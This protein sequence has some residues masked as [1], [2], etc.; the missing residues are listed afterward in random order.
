M[1]KTISINNYIL[2]AIIICIIGF[3]LP[4]LGALSSDAVKLLALF[5][6]SLLMWIF[7]AID[8]PSLLTILALGLV[9]AI[10]FG[11]AFSSAFGNSTVAFLI[12]TF[13]LVYPL[14]KTNF[15]KRCT[16]FFITNPLAAKG[17]W[18]FVI[19]LLAAVTFMGLFISP[20]VLFVAFMPFLE[21]IFKTLDLKKGSPSAKM[22]MT[23][24]AICINLS[25]GMT[26]IGHVWPT[27]A[28]GYYNSATGYNIGQFEY[29]AFG[30]PA[31][32]LIIALVLA[33]YRFIL[34][35]ADLKS[36][37][38]K[39]AEA[40]KK[41]IPQIEKSEKIILAVLALTVFLWVMPSL[42]SGVWPAF[43]ELLNSY[44]SAFPPLL[45]CLILFCINIDNK[46]LLDFK[47]ACTKGIMWGS[48]L[49]TAAATAL[50]A[51]LTSSEIG[52]S[53]FLSTYLGPLAQNL[54]PLLM[55]MFFMAWA[56]IETNF[57]SNIVTTTVVSSVALSIL[58]ALPQGSINIGAVLAM[59]GFAAAVC[60][61][62]P[63][64]Q[65]TVNTVAIGSGYTDTKT[66]FFIGLITAIIAFIV[67]VFLAYP[68]ASA[69]MPY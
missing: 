29:M 59:I 58:T 34:Y 66:M 2:A 48:V 69:L 22:L 54:S 40:L 11:E 68:L 41:R 44:T 7:V 42:L 33:V 37:D 61:M 38:L 63:A 23:C 21:D 43:Y 35:P 26:A 49:M 31:G 1:N 8:W 9:P 25:S 13:A 62:T 6:A 39:K 30:I 12:F 52:I 14:S 32:L 19:G 15:V 65:S 51:A 45:G 60:N 64:G 24:S 55:I 10:G 46:P 17:P 16:V 53:A 67:L 36:L 18:F 57:S 4:G 27:L 20:S 5:I 56:L 28:I 50:G 47:E 3:S